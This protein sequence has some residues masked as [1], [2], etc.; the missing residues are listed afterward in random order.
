M[1]V[2]ALIHF[3]MPWRCAGS[4]TVVQELMRA[5]AG[6]GHDAQVWCT[7]RDAQHGW[8]GREPDTDLDGVKVH[9]VR[10]VIVGSRHIQ[11]W[12]PD[13]VVSHHQHVMHAV[14]LARTI[15]AKSVFLL[16]NDMDL[17]QRPLGMRPDL[18][19]FNSEW[20][21]ESLS[22]FPGVGESMVMH[23][24]LTPDRHLVPATGDALTLINLNEHKGAHLFYKIAE[25]MP[26]RKFL[27]VIGGHGV[28]VVRRNLPNVEIMEHGPDMKRVWAKTRVLLMPSVYESYGLTAVEAGINGIPT[29]A[30]PTP[31]LVENLQWGPFADRDDPQAWVDQIEALDNTITYEAE[32]S[33]AMKR[34]EDAIAA[35]R[36]SLNEWCQ[37]LEAHTKGV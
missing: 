21:K 5:A 36:R 28:Q 1:K 7:N 25:T 22:R 35:T 29:I 33:D 18:C 20:V 34:S 30:N 16:H 17:N 24:P 4:E 2:A 37:W 8:T 19:V 15:K 14:R 13:V 3:S 11:A 32:A 9:R 6:A 12:R 31:G 27:G 10:N 26:D 23:P